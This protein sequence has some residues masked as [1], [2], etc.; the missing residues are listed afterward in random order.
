MFKT[1]DNYEKTAG[2]GRSDALAHAERRGPA[3]VHLHE[4]SGEQRNPHRHHSEDNPGPG[5]LPLAGIVVRTVPLRRLRLH[6]FQRQ[7][8]R[9]RPCPARRQARGHRIRRLRAALGAQLQ[10][11]A[12]PTGSPQPRRGKDHSPAGHRHLQ[13]E[14]HRLSLPHRARHHTQMRVL[15]QRGRLHP[16]QVFLPPQRRDR[17]SHKQGLR[18]QHLDP[19]QQGR[20]PQCGTPG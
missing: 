19:Y 3:V 15:T 18:G 16:E 5:R 10:Q 20:L 14:R 9:N 7:F 17:Q 13:A 8:L 6:P 4:V 2:L 11:D 12:L 1:C